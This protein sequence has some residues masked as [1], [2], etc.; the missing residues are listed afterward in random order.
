MINEYK[1]ISARCYSERTTI[2]LGFSMEYSGPINEL[3]ST[4]IYE[5]VEE[6]F[7]ENSHEFEPLIKVAKKLIESDNTIT[8]KDALQMVF[9][10][11]SVSF[12]VN[13]ISVAVYPGIDINDQLYSLLLQL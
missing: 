5:G 9:G 11:F 8:Y 10:R 4:W 13:G 3:S 2:S 12:S 6:S 1:E 7:W